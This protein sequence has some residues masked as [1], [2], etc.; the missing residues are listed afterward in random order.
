[1]ADVGLIPQRVLDELREYF[2]S[3]PATLEKGALVTKSWEVIRMPNAAPEL[4]RAALFQQ[5]DDD[6]MRFADLLEQDAVFCWAH[7]H[8]CFGNTPSG[9][10]ISHHQYAC[11][12]LIWSGSKDEFALYSVDDIKKIENGAN[13]CTRRFVPWMLKPFRGYGKPA[14]K[15][16]FH[17]GRSKEFYADMEY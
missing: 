1:M 6:A 10:D 4:S 17:D 12:M 9:I 2:K 13:R 14:T 3:A 11:H 8:P 16:N 5:N 7:S 15:R